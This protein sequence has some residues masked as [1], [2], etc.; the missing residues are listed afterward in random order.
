MQLPVC[1][2]KHK[3]DSTAGPNV[4]VCLLLVNKAS[5]KYRKLV[6][7]LQVGEPGRKFP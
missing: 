4:F 3:Q 7:S 6:E 1:L 2:R 5:K